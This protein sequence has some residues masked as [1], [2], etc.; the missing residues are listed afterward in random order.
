VTLFVKHYNIYLPTRWEVSK[1]PLHLPVTSDAIP[2]RST[3]VYDMRL[4]TV[5]QKKVRIR[6]NLLNLN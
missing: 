4:F 1:Y 2:L 6:H 3:M 5:E